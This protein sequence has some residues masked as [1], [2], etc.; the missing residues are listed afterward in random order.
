[1][2]HCIIKNIGN[3]TMMV[4]HKKQFIDFEKKNSLID[5]TLK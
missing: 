1:M 2:I 5:I 3:Y 4:L